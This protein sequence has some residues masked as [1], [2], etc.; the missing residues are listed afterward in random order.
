[1][2]LRHEIQRAEWDE[3]KG[4]WEVH[5]KDL[6]SGETFVDTADVFINGSGV[7]K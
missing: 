5:V 7:L 1:M 3:G 6:A 4:V 2:K